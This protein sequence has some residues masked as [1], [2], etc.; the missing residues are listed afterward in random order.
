M[1]PGIPGGLQLLGVGKA[2]QEELCDTLA[3]TA[4]F[5]DLAW[6]EIKALGAFMQGYQA[7][8]GTTIFKEGEVGQYM[9][10]ILSGS[11]AIEKED[12]QME[13]KTVAEVGAG[14]SIGEMAM[15]D[16]ERRSATCRTQKETTLA[17]LTR[18]KFERLVDEYPVL[19]VKILHKLARLLSQRLRL[20]S[21]ILVDYLEQ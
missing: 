6:P 7:P 12:R 19:G 14:K 3:D 18:D 8:A 17:I 20:A 9:C 5:N 1:E 2:F 21:G 15:I 10:V 11:V 13:H 4:L 16:G